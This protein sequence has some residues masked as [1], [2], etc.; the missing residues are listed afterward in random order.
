MTLRRYINIL[1]FQCV[2]FIGGG[3]ILLVF[4]RTN[5][6]YLPFFLVAIVGLTCASALGHVDERL[7]RLESAYA[8][9]RGRAG[10]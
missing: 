3:L 7:T 5:P 1:L 6:L 9:E 8:N 10:F 2:L 4:D